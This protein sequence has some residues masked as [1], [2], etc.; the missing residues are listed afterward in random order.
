[1]GSATRIVLAMAVVGAIAFAAGEEARGLTIVPTF[2]T[3]I[4]NDPSAATIEATINGAIATY[5]QTFSDPITVN[6]TFQESSSGLG[7][8]STAIFQ[9]SYSNYRT[10]L[11]NDAKTADD[12]IATGTLPN[13]PTTSPVDGNANMWVTTAN[14]RAIGLNT[15]VTSDGTISLN[16]SIMN[17]SR[18]G[19][20]NSTH[21]DLQA[22]AEHEI[23][24]VLGL[25][26]GLNLPTGF[27]R[28]S[29]PEDLFRYG[30]ANTRSYTTNS[31]ATSY[32]SIDGGATDLVNFNQAT[33]GSDFGDWASGPTV[34]VQDAFGTPGTQPNLGP[35]LTALDVIGYDRVTIVVPEPSAAALALAALGAARLAR[36]RAAKPRA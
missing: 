16:T 35:E 3:S 17:L 27:P 11:L 12:A 24:E 2:D 32:F 28:L 26:S 8:S 9:L 22:V 15:S 18:T 10:L 20:Q 19:P 25:G 14:G 23:D 6:I 13:L 21:Y 31:G 1:M 30:A 4:T 5:Q 7:S 36:R 33:G 34:H 29:R